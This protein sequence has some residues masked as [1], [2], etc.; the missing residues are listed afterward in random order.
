MSRDAVTTSIEQAIA[1]AANIIKSQ[2]RPG[3]CSYKVGQ[4]LYVFTS[5]AVTLTPAISTVAGQMPM[6]QDLD[7]VLFADQVTIYGWLTTPARN[8]TIVAR[9]IGTASD[10]RPH[11][12]PDHRRAA[13]VASGPP[14]GVNGDKGQITAAI[15][16]DASGTQDDGTGNSGNPGN[17]GADGTPGT[18][19]GDIRIFCDTTEAGVDLALRSTGGNGG[20][21]QDGQR[22][23][24]GATGKK[25]DDA[26]MWSSATAG[27]PGGDGGTGGKGGDAA[28]GGKGGTLVFHA[29]DSNALLPKT[30]SDGVN[31][32]T[33]GAPGHGAFGG[34]KGAGGAGGA[35]QQ[36]NEATG[37]E[38]SGY[39]DQGADGTGYDTAKADDGVVTGVPAG[40]TY[41]RRNGSMDINHISQRL[42]PYGFVD[43]AF[44]ALDWG[45]IDLLSYLEMELEQAGYDY[46]AL[47]VPV[48]VATSDVSSAATVG[49]AVSRLEWILDLAAAAPA[50]VTDGGVGGSAASDRLADIIQRAD[51]LLDRIQE[52]LDYFGHDPSWVPTLSLAYYEAQLGLDAD[53]PDGALNVYADAETN[54]ARL[55]SALEIG[56]DATETRRAIQS[57][58][59]NR[60]STV[61]EQIKDLQDQRATLLEKIKEQDAKLP[62]LRAALETAV[63]SWEDITKIGN[64]ALSIEKVFDTVG[65]FAFFPEKEGPMLAYQQAAMVIGQ[66][67]SAASSLFSSDPQHDYVLNQ[68]RVVDDKAGALDT[69]FSTL[70]DD[71][72]IKV[73]AFNGQLLLST[74]QSFDDFCDANWSGYARDAKLAMDKWVDGVQDRNST[75][76]QYNQTLSSLNGALASQAALT[77]LS[78]IDVDDQAGATNQDLPESAVQASITLTTARE[79]CLRLLYEAS[80]AFSLAT[81]QPDLTFH[82]TLGLSAPTLIT[83]AAASTA[84][85][86]LVTKRRGTLDARMPQ[87]HLPSETGEIETQF[88]RAGGV[89]F[90]ISRDTVTGASS[91]FQPLSSDD[92]QTL[93]TSLATGTAMLKLDPYALCMDP[94]A[95]FYQMINVRVRAIRCWLHG[96]AVRNAPGIIHVQLTHTGDSTFVTNADG[97]LD[98]RDHDQVTRDFRYRAA[99]AGPDDDY[100][101]IYDKSLGGVQDGILIDDTNA[102]ALL[103]PFATWRIAL[104]SVP[105]GQPG[106][107]G[108]SSGSP[109]EPDPNQ[110]DASSLTAIHLEFFIDYDDI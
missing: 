18:D 81:F 96:F 68:L 10:T 100:R 61:A 88:G 31:G 108:A 47:P 4:T 85:N 23:G 84:A 64:T 54:Y 79:E 102:H 87:Q 34:A 14:D 53:R 29:L 48:D 50:A 8:A 28:I 92:T 69:S 3:Y 70:S 86:N 27:S 74:R 65:Q 62:T 104:P 82:A 63:G 43:E 105:Q 36:D 109:A 35:W 16:S 73:D 98:S 26:G 2:V 94:T 22:G 5:E 90:T 46:L 110:D 52:G 75:I 95:P 67:G 19:G 49:I 106:T 103:S 39:M 78:D 38:T 83:A 55:Q 45:H 71:G 11:T 20:S 42:Q 40:T 1:Q 15:Q 6:P 58:A 25:G 9:T 17:K 99:M 30:A 91:A 72:S 13:I 80:R 37:G 44:A 24:N 59:S 12:D 77:R 56:A 21:G 101:A 89:D 76:L 60:L 97:D 57:L 33:A 66:G 51:S 41:V 32:G 93:F 7:L 107:D